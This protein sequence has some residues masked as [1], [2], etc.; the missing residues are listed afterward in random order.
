[1]PGKTQFTRK[2]I[3]TLPG[4]CPSPSFILSLPPFLFLSVLEYFW[5]ILRLRGPEASRVSS[6]GSLSDNPG[7]SLNSLA[8]KSCEMQIMKHLITTVGK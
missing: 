4:L 3:V 7:L 2:G 1:M 5:A 8:I 6:G